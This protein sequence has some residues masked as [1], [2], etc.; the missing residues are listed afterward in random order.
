MNTNGL[1]IVTILFLSAIA[2]RTMSLSYEEDSFL[3]NSSI[4]VCP[5]VVCLFIAYYSF[6]AYAFISKEPVGYWGI[7]EWILVGIVFEIWTIP[8]SVASLSFNKELLDKLRE[9]E[10]RLTSLESKTS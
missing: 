2:Y 10:K 3:R 6:F 9:T 4:V 5:L 7:K 8:D 1:I